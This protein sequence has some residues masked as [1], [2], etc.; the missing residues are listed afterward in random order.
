MEWRERREVEGR[1]RKKM[2]RKITDGR[3]KIRTWRGRWGGGRGWRKVEVKD[4]SNER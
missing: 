3:K 1:G 2:W 4:G